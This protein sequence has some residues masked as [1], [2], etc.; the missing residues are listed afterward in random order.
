MRGSG[1]GGMVIVSLTLQVVVLASDG[2][3]VS[4]D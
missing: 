4:V 2:N 1:L 3:V